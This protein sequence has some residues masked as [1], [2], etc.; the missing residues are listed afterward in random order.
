MNLQKIIVAICS[1]LFFMIDIDKFFPFMEPSCSM[2]ENI[3]PAMWM[4]LG[5]IDIAAG[6]LI[7][8]D[9][10]RKFIAGFFFVLMIGFSVMHLVN[11]TSDIGGALFM[12]ALLGLLL[13][14][15]VF[16]R[17]KN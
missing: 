16:L 6:I 14:D 13:W 15:P 5:V 3:S 10:Y 8:V 7:W 11:D 17:P 1:L 9:K 4:F 2:M 12:A